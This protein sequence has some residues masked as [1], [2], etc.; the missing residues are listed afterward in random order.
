MTKEEYTSYLKSEYWKGY[1]YAIIKE[2]EFICQDC[3]KQFY[4][5]RNR[6]QV[7]HL[8]Y[9]DVKPWSYKPDEIV[10]LCEECHK[11]RHGI[12]S[13]PK[14]PVSQNKWLEDNFSYITETPKPPRS[15]ATIIVTVVVILTLIVLGIMSF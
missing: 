11:R 4:N 8:H 9:R 2:R 13:V 1:S 7:H 5:Q 12:I 6:L 3:G 14:R 10:V 15:K